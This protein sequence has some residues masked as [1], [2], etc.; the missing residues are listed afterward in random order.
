M[1]DAMDWVSTTDDGGAAESQSGTSVIVVAS[2]DSD[3]TGGGGYKCTACNKKIRTTYD[4]QLHPLLGVLLCRECYTSYGNGDFS[5]FEQGVDEDGDDNFCRWCVDGGEL[6]ICM[7]TDEN[8]VTCHYSFC[9]DCITRNLPDDPILRCDFNNP[10]GGYVFRCY[11]C[12]PSRL[13]E[14]RQKAASVMKELAKQE[15]HNGQPEDERM[16]DQGMD[17]ESEGEQEIVAERVEEQKKDGESDKEKLAQKEESPRMEEPAEKE[18]SIQKVEPIPKEKPVQKERLIQ[19]EEPPRKEGSIQKDRPTQR[20]ESVP[21]GKQ[22]QKERSLQNG[23]SLLKEKP[24]QKDKSAQKEKLSQKERPVQKEK[25]VV[26][27]KPVLKEDTVHNMVS[28]PEEEPPASTVELSKCELDQR[29]SYFAHIKDSCIDEINTK[30]D[31]IVK[32]LYSSQMD[33]KL[34]RIVTDEIGSLKKP[35]QDIADMLD[36]L[37]RL[38]RIFTLI[39]R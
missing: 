18:E 1:G 7:N 24:V 16:D 31:D 21:K 22:A 4:A 14:L 25:T 28:V 39:K 13:D 26:K 32:S 5:K 34:R 9:R 19:K 23:E 3:K 8:G 15:F 37:Q 10:S 36:D 12:E 33:D 2:Q 20:E 27:E 35:M 11:A 30:F 6:L 17:K 29:L 38:S